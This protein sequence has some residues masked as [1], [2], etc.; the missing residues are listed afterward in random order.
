MRDV[1]QGEVA[2]VP[3]DG[4]VDGVRQAH[5]VFLVRRGHRLLEIVQFAAQGIVPPLRLEI[6][7]ALVAVD[8]ELRIARDNLAQRVHAADIGVR[9]DA[10][11][12]LEGPI[13]SAV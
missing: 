11:L 3:R 7:V 1:V 8:V 2:L 12:H 4:N 10:A 6:R 9:V 13:P 5:A